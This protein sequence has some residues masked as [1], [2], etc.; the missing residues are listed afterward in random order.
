MMSE[1]LE[2]NYLL[3]Y[4]TVETLVEYG[5][6]MKIC[7]RRN[8][9]GD[10]WLEATSVSSTEIP[11]RYC[12]CTPCDTIYSSVSG[13]ISADH[14]DCFDRWSKCPINVSLPTNE[15]E[16]ELLLIYFQF[17]MSDDGYEKSNSNDKD[18]YV[19]S[20]DEIEQLLRNPD[21]VDN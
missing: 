5:Y 12:F 6:E 1:I 7:K 2:K 19:T 21:E 17:L 11:L 3:F 8:E 20:Y 13:K 10:E 18:W 14:V 16:F 15:K 9:D 4:Q